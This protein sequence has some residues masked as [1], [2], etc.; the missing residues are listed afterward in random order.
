[1][2]RNLRPLKVIG[3]ALLNIH[4]FIIVVATGIGILYGLW[5]LGCRIITALSEAWHCDGSTAFA[6]LLL[7]LVGIYLIGC[8]CYWIY[9]EADK[10][11]GEIEKNRWRNAIDNGYKFILYKQKEHGIDQE[12]ITREVVD[13][14]YM[15]RNE[16]YS[17]DYLYS[18]KRSLDGYGNRYDITYDHKNKTVLLK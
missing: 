9:T 5:K 2:R 18:Y 14:W 12:D 7:I 16:Y 13:E 8:L 4:L 11:L 6:L 3:L 1:M 15:Y 17:S 10:Q